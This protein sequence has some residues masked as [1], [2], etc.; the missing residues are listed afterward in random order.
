MIKRDII[1]IGASA[2]GSEAILKL[3]SYLT[4][5]LQAAVFIVW[6][7]GRESTG[8]LPQ[9]ISKVTNI[10]IRNAADGERFS[11]GNIYV[12]PPDMHLLVEDGITR[13]TRGPKE[14]R[15]RPA[16]DPLFRSAAY[17]HGSRV[18]GIILSG[19]LNDGTSGLW[20]IK[21]RGG[22]VIA[23]SPEE[24]QFSGMPEEAIRNVEV[25][26]I[27]TVREISMLLPELI[28]KEVKIEKSSPSDNLTIE[29]EYAS[30][31]INGSD[32]MEKIG[33]LTPYT[34]PECHGSLWKV[35][36]EKPLRY[37]CHTGHAYTAEHL[38]ADLGETIDI[39][40][41]NTIRGI[42]EQ[43]RLFKLMADNN[44]NKRTDYNVELNKILKKAEI[45]KELV[46]FK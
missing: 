46:Q 3:C 28:Q 13:T 41:W 15:V 23:Q 14:N 36:D 42:E 32:K 26:H 21:E 29:V 11:N 38:A 24:A 34:C 22:I 5:D 8:Y 20:S 16:I 33:E 43:A 19:M 6:H 30:G 39:Y 2:G 44:P 45:L 10:P 4:P 25:D 18:I 7:L 12:A 1:V 40:L 27:S 37:R 31:K 35:M 17:Y 9:M